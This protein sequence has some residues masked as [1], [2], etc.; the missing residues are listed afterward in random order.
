MERIYDISI[1]VEIETNKI[2]YKNYYDNPYTAV[3]NL[4]N[5]LSD[6]ERVEIINKYC[7]HCGCTDPSCQC[8]NDA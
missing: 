8:W 2:T 6:M 3:V 1:L 4:F 7:K 5:K